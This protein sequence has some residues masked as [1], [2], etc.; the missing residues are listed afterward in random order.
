M[1]GALR[2]RHREGACFRLA[3]RPADA[4]RRRS[5]GER[6]EP[7]R[8]SRPS[9]RSAG[10]ERNNSVPAVAV[11]AALRRRQCFHPG[12]SLP[13]RGCDRYPVPLLAA[14]DRGD[15]IYPTEAMGLP[16]RFKSNLELEVVH[17][18][19]EFFKGR[20]WLATVSLATALAVT[21]FYGLRAATLGQ[22]LSKIRR[23]PSRWPRAPRRLPGA[24]TRPS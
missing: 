12:L 11:C 21:G 6:S 1:I 17:M 7:C 3:S 13:K 15:S 14:T 19:I 9:G 22:D 18:R 4:L 16:K 20:R 2:A 10:R 8:R 24:D 23:R 5:R